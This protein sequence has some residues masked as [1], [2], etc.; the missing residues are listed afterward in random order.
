MGYG[1]ENDSRPWRTWISRPTVCT[2]KRA[3]TMRICVYFEDLCCYVNLFAAKLRM[4]LFDSEI[5][6]FGIDQ[7]MVFD[8]GRKV[9]GLFCCYIFIL[10]AVWSFSLIHSG[11]GNGLLLYSSDPTRYPL[12]LNPLPIRR[13]LVQKVCL[14]RLDTLQ[15]NAP[16]SEFVGTYFIYYAWNK[17]FNNRSE[18]VGQTKP[19]GASI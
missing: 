15:P 6:K 5:S 9:I 2:L 19:S 8:A 14:T 4:I 1:R 18:L 16:F 10:C 7:Y 11:I 17:L 3:A 13:V 12:R